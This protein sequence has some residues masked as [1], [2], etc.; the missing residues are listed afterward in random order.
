MDAFHKNIPCAKIKLGN[1]FY[2]VTEMRPQCVNYL[3]INYLMKCIWKTFFGNVEGSFLFYF[4]RSIAQF[5]WWYEHS[6]YEVLNGSW[7]VEHVYSQNYYKFNCVH[8]EWTIYG[9]NKCSIFGIIFYET[10]TSSMFQLSI[11]TSVH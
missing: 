6:V 10:M 7:N 2:Y 4:H 9:Y 1:Y 8:T 5:R 11:Y 3:S